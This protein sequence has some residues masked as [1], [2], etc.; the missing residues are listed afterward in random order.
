[1]E[2]GHEVL[3]ELHAELDG[4]ARVVRMQLLAS[5]LYEA[6][7]A[8]HAASPKDDAGRISRLAGA[9]DQCRRAADGGL[10]QF[11]VSGVRGALT[12][13]ATS[14]TAEQTFRVIQGGRAA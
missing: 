8:V 10:P 6:I 3:A 4:S 13:L 7:K 1:M 5:R 14:P 12:I 9:L 2:L 11:I